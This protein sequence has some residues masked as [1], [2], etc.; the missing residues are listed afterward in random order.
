MAGFFLP[1]S[2]G[3]DSA[4]TAV[5]VGSMCDLVME[6]IQKGSPR[7]TEDLRR[8]L[9]LPEDQPFPADAVKLAGSVFPYHYVILG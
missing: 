7:V 8:V 9:Q 2:G 3:I 1:L 4:S 5:L 6:A